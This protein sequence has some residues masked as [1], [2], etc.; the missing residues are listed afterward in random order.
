MKRPG[1]YSPTEVSLGLSDEPDVGFLLGMALVDAVEP[2]RQRASLRIA[3]NDPTAAWQDLFTAIRLTR[4]V[5]NKNIVG[6]LIASA[7]FNAVCDQL[8]HLLAC[9]ETSAELVQQVQRDLAQIDNPNQEILDCLHAERI[10]SA[11]CLVD[12]ANGGTALEDEMEGS[13][14]PSIRI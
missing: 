9:P 5:P 6:Y 13:D 4:R 1:F 3:N 2:L 14:A 11:S 12:I 10:F 8:R 7:Q